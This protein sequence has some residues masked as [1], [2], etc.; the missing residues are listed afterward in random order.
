MPMK[1]RMRNHWASS[2][3]L[4]STG[5]A[6]KSAMR[7]SSPLRR[8]SSIASLARQ[9]LR[10]LRRAAQHEMDVGGEAQRMLFDTRPF[11]PPPGGGG[12]SNAVGE[13]A[14]DDAGQ[15]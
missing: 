11:L 7:R 15:E 3:W 1:A 13:E 4:I 5:R 6:Y 14:V 2:V 10:C 8:S 12:G 9:H